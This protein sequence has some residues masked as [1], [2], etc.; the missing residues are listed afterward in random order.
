MLSGESN[1]FK[2]VEQEKGTQNGWGRRKMIRMIKLAG[3]KV[4]IDNKHCADVFFLIQS[5]N[6]RINSKIDC[7]HDQLSANAIIVDAGGNA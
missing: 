2:G 5:L 4:K 1:N 3:S 6:T 7:Q